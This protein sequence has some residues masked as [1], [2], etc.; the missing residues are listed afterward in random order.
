M[1]TGGTSISAGLREKIAPQIAAAFGHTFWWAVAIAG[2]AL[3]PALFLSRKPA[4]QVS[5]AAARAAPVSPDGGPDS[6]GDRPID[7]PG[8]APGDGPGDAPGITD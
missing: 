1:T 6:P 5:L 4:I 8:D 3:V 2:L 7:G